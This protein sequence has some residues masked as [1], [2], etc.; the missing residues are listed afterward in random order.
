MLF[1]GVHIVNCTVQY[2]GGKMKREDRGDSE[3][4]KACAE[5]RSAQSQLGR[6]FRRVQIPILPM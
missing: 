4:A 3:P 6:T 5:A 1:W 2:N